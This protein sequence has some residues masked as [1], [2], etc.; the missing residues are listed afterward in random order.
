VRAAVDEHG[1]ILGLDDE[2]WF[3]QGGYLRTHGVA[4]TELT[5]AMLPGPYMIPA[6]RSVGHVRLT[7]KTPCG[8][9]Q[10]ARAIEP[11]HRHRDRTVDRAGPQGHRPK[12]WM[13]ASEAID[14]GLAYKIVHSIEDLK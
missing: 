1:F 7:N 4:V 9:H 13:S 10:D 2:F 14:Y 8:D 11:D 5:C 3:D 6:Y 12:F